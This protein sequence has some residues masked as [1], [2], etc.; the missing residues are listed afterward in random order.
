MFLD[1]VWY[2]SRRGCLQAELQHEMAFCFGG[3]NHLII[4]AI[5]LHTFD[6]LRGLNRDWNEMCYREE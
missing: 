5:I 2:S 4:C 6:L 1:H 3:E